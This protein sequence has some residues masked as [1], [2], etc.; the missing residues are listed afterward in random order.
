MET[1]QYDNKVVWCKTEALANRFLLLAHQ[2][3]YH[4]S[5]TN[6]LLTYNHYDDY[7]DQTCYSLHKVEGCHPFVTYESKDY[8][9]EEGK[10]IIEFKGGE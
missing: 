9:K 10:E 8:Y 5:S 7:E 4:W 6:S 3:D 2:N 1:F